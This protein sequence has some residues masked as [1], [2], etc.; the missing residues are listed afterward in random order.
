M[1]NKCIE[2]LE[3]AEK[4]GVKIVVDAKSWEGPALGFP[5]FADISPARCELVAEARRLANALDRPPEPPEG[6]VYRHT[7][8]ALSAAL[9]RAT[10]YIETHMEGKPDAKSNKH[11]A[12]ALEPPAN[13]GNSGQPATDL[14]GDG[15]TDTGNAP[16]PNKGKAAKG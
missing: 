7:K 3:R 2:V 14:C 13:A 12:K 10:G 16:V 6:C 8:E 15:G 1:P 9:T 11:T 4:A 5:L